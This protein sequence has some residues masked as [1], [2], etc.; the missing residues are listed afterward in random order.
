MKTIFI[1]EYKNQESGFDDESFVFDLS[2]VKVNHC[3]GCWSC[4]WKTPG[5]CI[6]K[7]LN[8]FYHEYITS[9][10][11]VFFA[12]ISKGFVTSNMKNLFD[13]MIPLYLPYTS[14]KTGESMHVK[15]YKKYPSIEFYYNSQAL[16]EEQRNIFENYINRVF[17]Q[18]YSK[19]IRICDIN[20]Y[21][22]KS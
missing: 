18:F 22:E 3:T 21:K 9:D 19:M 10:R 11:A 15:R 16:T 12:N 4:W 1:N 14:F 13:R 2:K 17:Y 5:R 20:E 8:K 7:D 6:Y